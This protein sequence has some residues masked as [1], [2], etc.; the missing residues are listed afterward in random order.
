MEDG[1]QSGFIESMRV[2]C[3]K[4]EEAPEKLEAIARVLAKFGQALSEFSEGK[5]GVA[6]VTKEGGHGLVNDFIVGR[7]LNVVLVSFVHPD[8]PK[9]IVGELEISP[10]GFPARLEI[11]GLSQSAVDVR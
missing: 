10:F 3:R 5:V 11:E 8:L 7:P 4:L 1:Q 6:C 9:P 2:G